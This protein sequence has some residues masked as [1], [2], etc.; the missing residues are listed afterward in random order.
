MQTSEIHRAHH[1]LGGDTLL[2][3]EHLTRRHRGLGRLSGSHRGAGGRG[4]GSVDGGGCRSR[5]GVF[6]LRTGG[7]QAGRVQINPA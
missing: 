7:S 6:L 1:D 2:G 3:Q 5:R 4:G